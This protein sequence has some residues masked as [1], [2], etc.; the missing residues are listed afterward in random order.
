VVPSARSRPWPAV[1]I[2]VAA[3]VAYAWIAAGLRPFTW[4]ENVFVA[5]PMI[6]VVVL[7]ARRNRPSDP[8]APARSPQRG[9]I[10]WAGLA[11]AVAAWEL[12]A[13][14]SSPRDDHPT[15]SSIADWIMSVHAGRA[16][17]VGAWLLVGAALALRP[18]RGTSR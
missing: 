13:L 17:M 11:L 15:M 14:F 7:A 10:V 1:A 16:A 12:G 8:M 5:L 4:P 3:V 2:V 9:T 6:P 18:K